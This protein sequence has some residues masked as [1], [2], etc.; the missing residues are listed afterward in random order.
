MERIAT[1]FSVARAT[2]RR[3]AAATHAGSENGTDSRV[4]LPDVILEKSRM[5][6]MTVRRCSPL[7][8]M[9]STL[10][11]CAGESGVSRRRVVMPMTAFMGVRI[12]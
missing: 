1:F 11:R 10:S 7:D 2:R 3:T 8:W 5:S 12:S 6:L 9:T 4:S